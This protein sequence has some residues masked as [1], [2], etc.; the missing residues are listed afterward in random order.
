M[1]KKYVPAGVF[2]TCDKGT[3]P[4]QLTVTFNANT[5]IYGQSLATEADKIPLVNVKPMGVC[6]VGGG[7]CVPA[8]LLW[9]PVQNDVVV[10]NNRLL[11]EDSKLQCTKT[12]RI[13]IFFSMAEAMAAAAP[14]PAPEKSLLDKADDYLATL[15]PVGDYARFQMGMAE[16]LYAGGKSMVEG[17][18]GLAKGGWHAATHPVETANAIGDAA[19]SAADWASKGENWSNAAS[20]AGDGISSAADWASKGENWGNAWD[21]ASDWASQQSPRDWGKIGGRVTFEVAMTVGTGGAGAAAGAA[22]KAGT[23]ANLLGKAGEAANLADK[24]ADAVRL[25]DKAADAANLAS[26]AGEA[27]NAAGKAGVVGKVT[28]GADEASDAARAAKAA[29]EAAAARAQTYEELAQKPPCFLAGTLVHTPAGTRAIEQLVAG[30]L[31][32]AYDFE[33]GQAVPRPIVG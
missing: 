26:K 28:T 11:L 6:I 8:P 30:E 4:S 22:G 27:G 13:S 7:P 16:G 31:V 33:T 25:A 2:L 14:A 29:E 19:S 10:G 23:A 12:G 24:A 32:W 20:A 15:G 5:S 21:G 1:E 9:N 3:L 18:W 17:L